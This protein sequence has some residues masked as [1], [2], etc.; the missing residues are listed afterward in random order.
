MSEA[1]EEGRQAG[2]QP[3]RNRRRTRSQRAAGLGEP[4]FD[5]IEGDLAKA[6]FA[7]PAV[8]GVEF[9]SG[10]LRR[11]RGSENNDAFEIDGGKVVASP[12]MPVVYWGNQ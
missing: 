10:F 9:G 2:R 5:T 4:V 11:T 7:I 3:G 6:L 8:K 12:T 1:I